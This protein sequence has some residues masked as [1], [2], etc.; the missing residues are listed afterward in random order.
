MKLAHENQ[1]PSEDDARA[2]VVSLLGGLRVDD[3]AEAPSLAHERE[4]R[5]IR[6]RALWR[7]LSVAPEE[8]RTLEHP[9]ELRALPVVRDFLASRRK[10][11][12]LAGGEGAGKT[13]AALWALGELAIGWRQAQPFVYAQDLVMHS[14]YDPSW[15]EELTRHPLLVIDECGREAADDRG[16]FGSKFYYLLNAR[17]HARRK[18]ILTTNMERK[19]FVHRYLRG[20]E[21]TLLLARFREEGESFTRVQGESLRTPSQRA[22]AQTT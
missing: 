5:A 16:Y 15:W 19:D 21:G 14:L 2:F 20:P 17:Y 10:F 22:K 6:R 3:N 11:L 12:I 8:I 1:P 4:Q 9:F 18:T 7:D 13:F